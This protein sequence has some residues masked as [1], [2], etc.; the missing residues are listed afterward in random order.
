MIKLILENWRHCMK[1]N[2]EQEQIVKH[3]RN[4]TGTNCDWIPEIGFYKQFIVDYMN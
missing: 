4:Y 2:A 3:E 1:V